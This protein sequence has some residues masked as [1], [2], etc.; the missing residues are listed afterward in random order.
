MLANY[1][2]IAWRH[3]I[4]DKFYSS[5]HILGLATGIA[6][7][8]LALLVVGHELAYDSF[9]GKRE[10]IYR[11]LRERSG[12]SETGVRWL[13]SGA[14]ARAL[15]SDFA[16]VELATKC[17][18]YPVRARYGT[19][20]FENV[21]Q[22]HV[23]ENFFRVFDFALLAGDPDSALD[24]PYT[25]LISEK[26]ARR[27]FGAENPLGKVLSL[28]ERYYGGD[29]I[30]TGVLKDP[31]NQASSLQFDLLHATQGRDESAQTDWSSWQGRIQQAGIQTFALLDH[32]RSLPQLE[33]KLPDF[34]E[35]HMGRA[36][37][38]V[39]RYRLQPLERMHLYARQDYGLDEGGDIRSLY[40]F[41]AVALLVLA[42]VCI[43]FV[44]L[45]TARAAARAHEIGI[46]KALGASRAQLVAQFL[47]ESLLY[48]AIALVAALAIVAWVL[49]EFNALLGGDFHLDGPTLLDLAPSLIALAVFTGSMAGLYPAFYLSSFAPSRALKGRLAH[50]HQNWLRR[51][52]VAGQFAISILLITGTI[53][54][55]QQIEYINSKEL[56]F[57]REHFVLLPIFALQR[58]HSEQDDEWLSGRYNAVKQAFSAHPNVRAATAFRFLPGHSGGMVRLVKP[59]GHD[60]GEWRMP[61]Q[62]AD[63]SFFA[64]FSIELLAG[65]TFSPANERDRTHSYI[66]NE[67]AVR[68]LG[69]TV[70]NAVGRRFGRARS[71]ED[72]AGTVI[73][74]VRDFHYASLREPIEPAAIAYRQWFYD[75]LGLRISGEGTVETLA[76]IEKQ[77]RQFMSADQPF[78]YSFLDRE[79]EASYRAEKRLRHMVAI[80]SL[81][82]IF[83]ACLGLFGLVS[84]SAQQRTREIGIRK[85]LG[86]STLQIALLLSRDFIALVALANLVAWPVAHYAIERWLESFAYRVDMAW[87][88]FVIG[89]ASTLVIA[90]CITSYQAFRAA[91]TNPI[92]ALRNE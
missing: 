45:S 29:Y 65:R 59:E 78:T 36:V 51:V 32:S 81:L 1:C 30:I 60:D 6:C 82:A 87:W 89:G 13:S 61:V 39:L 8:V 3:I 47:G 56:G 72:A 27:I 31:P 92:E 22:G 2:K 68:A 14:L 84:L 67:K 74:V 76:F 24:R 73:G 11:V 86:A 35:R 21:V 17:R 10:R 70:E 23:D 57:A 80:F 64:A 5:V 55:H 15:E 34:I 58:D 19:R 79:I 16:E 12:G 9:H 54:V 26:A 85:V 48:A 71:T 33:S 18:I 62:E 38:E 49:P 50:A 40:L 90:W 37:R 63:E 41:A 43:N 46:R 77:W 42:I 88:F 91:I 44:N 83:L 75:Y 69:W 4:G 7:C 25:A 53:A 28:S 52:L 20:T 66:L